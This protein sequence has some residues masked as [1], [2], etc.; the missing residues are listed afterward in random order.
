MG[1]AFWDAFARPAS[2][3]GRGGAKA[4]WD[5]DKVRKILE[6][7]AVVRVVDVETPISGSSS[8]D[9]LEESMRSMSLSGQSESTNTCNL[10]SRTRAA[11]VG[12]K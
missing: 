8:T 6:G 9:A 2:A 1:C 5:H 11:V 10:F 7:K 3:T 4:D 12:K